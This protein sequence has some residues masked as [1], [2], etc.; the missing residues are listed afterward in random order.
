MKRD[1]DA[2]ACL[3][4][5]GDGDGVHRCVH[6]HRCAHARRWMRAHHYD[7][8]HCEI[9]QSGDGGD[10]E[11]VSLLLPLFVSASY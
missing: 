11:V 10:D 7:A 9:H 4:S 6:A 1:D 3:C 2:C 8:R 5:S